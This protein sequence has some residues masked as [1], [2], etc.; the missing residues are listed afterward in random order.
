MYNIV[1]AYFILSLIMKQ[2]TKRIECLQ[3]LIDSA[4]QADVHKLLYSH[5]PDVSI[6]LS[7]A[8][9]NEEELQACLNNEKNVSNKM[10]CVL[11]E[12]NL[13]ETLDKNNCRTDARVNRSRE[14]IENRKRILENGVVGLNDYIDYISHALDKMV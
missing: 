8:N 13:Q 9:R 5:L 14:L 2:K 7:K 4:L 10:Q 1:E 3:G 6:A 12:I 11:R